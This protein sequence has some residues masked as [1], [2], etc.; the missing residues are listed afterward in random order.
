MNEKTCTNVFLLCSLQKVY[1]S[2]TN[3]IELTNLDRGESY[4]FYVQAY[5]P[6]RSI[7]KQLGEVSQTQ[8]SNDDSKSILEGEVSRFLYP[9]HT[10]KITAKNLRSPS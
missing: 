8:C 6:S 2:K 5:I 7:D 3:V 1:D 9:F 10:G 4:C